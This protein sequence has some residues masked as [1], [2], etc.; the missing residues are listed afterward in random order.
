M[1]KGGRSGIGSVRGRK[2][3]QSLSNEALFASLNYNS[4]VRCSNNCLKQLPVLTAK[5]PIRTCSREKDAKGKVTEEA[6]PGMQVRL[7]VTCNKVES[8]KLWGSR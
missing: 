6:A 7:E 2:G 8:M 1:A 4:H 5:D 3:S